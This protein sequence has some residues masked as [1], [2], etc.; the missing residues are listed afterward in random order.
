MKQ[1]AKNALKCVSVNVGLTVVFLI[2]SNVGMMIN[3][4]VNAKNWLIKAYAMKDLLGIPVIVS[5]NVI[6]PVILVSIWTITITKK[7]QKKISK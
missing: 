6:N 5:A 2:I 1:H 7:V 3:A 4:G